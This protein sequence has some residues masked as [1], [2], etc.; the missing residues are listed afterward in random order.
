MGATRDEPAFDA[1][2]VARGQRLL[3]TAYLLTHDQQLAEDLVQT[4]LAKAW[5]RWARIEDEPE[6]YVRR[7]M[8]HTY[9][10]WWRRRWRGE[11][12]HE[13]LPEHPVRAD[14]GDDADTRHDLWSAL[15]RLAPRQRAVLVLRYVE[16]LTEA[17][18]ATALGVSVGTVKSTAHRA[19]ARLRL[20]GALVRPEQDR[21]R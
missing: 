4:A 6:A 16:D 9:A 13:R 8:A 17:Q 3:H 10:S 14:E 19:L 12:P 20:D 18:T 5:G 11:A 2:V 7:I 1:F 21:T 15:G